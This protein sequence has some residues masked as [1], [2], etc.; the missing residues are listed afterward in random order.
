MNA[1]GIST[2]Y[3]A[4]DVETCVAELRPMVHGCVV[5]GTFKFLHPM[6]VLDLRLID[7]AA[8]K[9]SW[10]DPEF[11]EKHAAG[12]FIRNLHD[13]MRVPV[14]PEA[15]ALEYLPTQVI[16]EYLASNDVDGVLY[17]SS[18]IDREKP[19]EEG[20]LVRLRDVDDEGVNLVLFARSSLVMGVP[21]E[22][23]WKIVLVGSLSENGLMDTQYVER[24]PL[25]GGGEVEEHPLV[26]DAL[27]P[28]LEFVE[29]SVAICVVKGIKHELIT[30]KVDFYEPDK[31]TA[32]GLPF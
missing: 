29:D 2:F 11:S 24:T 9:L 3:G 21:D 14:F 15:D 10:F 32:N 1:E 30:G 20:G 19:D 25:E 27:E 18:L 23:E 28:T 6:T 26:D 17:V 5:V 7:N 13:I 31:S 4:L 16:A 12:A 8:P 22:V